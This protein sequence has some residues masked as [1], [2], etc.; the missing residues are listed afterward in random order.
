MVR[1]LI[2]NYGILG[3]AV[4]ALMGCSHGLTGERQPVAG[5]VTLDGK[6]LPYAF[7]EFAQDADK[8]QVQTAVVTAGKFDLP[9]SIGL[10]VGRYTVCLLP[11]VPEADVL[12]KAPEKERLAISA[13]S[14]L[15]PEAYRR[16]GSLE[17]VV[18]AGG[19]A[20]FVFALSRPK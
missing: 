15:I 8:G 19:K 2:R 3:V 4:L 17:A 7:I 9:A 10:P 16:R 14:D 11:Y 18:E 6:P 1:F 13:A 20:D 12:E 5:T